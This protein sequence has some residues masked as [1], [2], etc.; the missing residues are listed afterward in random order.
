MPKKKKLKTS[1]I[2]LFVLGCL[3]THFYLPRIIIEIKNP[4]VTTLTNNKGIVSKKPYWFKDIEVSSF[5][6][7]K[8]KGFIR[9][10]E[11]DTV[12]G[13]IILLH[14]IR[15]QKEHFFTLSK[16][17]TQNGF[18]AIAF[19]SRAHNGSEGDF[20]TFGVK[21]KK[22]ISEIINTLEKNNKLKNNIGIWGQSLGGA[23]GLQAMG[24]D[25]RI[26]F[27]IIESTFSDFKPITHDYFKNNLV[28]NIPLFTNYLVSRAGSIGDFNPDDAKPKEYC[29]NITQPIL[30]VHGSKDKRVNIKY[31][32]ENFEAI[33]SSQKQFLE[34]KEGTHLNIHKVGGKEY[35]GKVFN[36][37]DSN[38]Q[39]QVY[40]NL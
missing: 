2:I 3:F 35:F 27:G 30:I 20:C 1:L 26:K 31:G 38:T 33:T 16:L 14:G 5:D 39:P 8:L 7:V 40:R 18:N 13:S 9:Y 10:T 22:D 34:I 28:F 36:F 37:I 15:S 24:S 17:I 21:E 32:K 23:I 6:G 4:I 25:K 29:K 12:K 11:S 19:D